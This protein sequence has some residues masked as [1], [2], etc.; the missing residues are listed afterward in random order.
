MTKSLVKRLVRLQHRYGGAMLALGPTV[1]VASVCFY[2]SIAWMTYISFTRSRLL[3]RYNWVGALQYERLLTEDR[4]HVA[5]ANLVV[6]GGCLVVGALVLGAL[7]A[8]AMDQ[9]I[10]FEGTL[11]TIF[12]Y[13]LA[14]SYVVTGLVW[15]WLLNPDFGL[16][17]V[18]RQMGFAEFHVDMLASSRLARFGI[19]AAAIWHAAGL[20]MALLLAA[21]RNVDGE[22]WRVARV[23]GI[24]TWRMYWHVILPM[25]ASAV[26]TCAVLLALQA[27]KGYDLVVAMTGG[28]PGYATDLPGKFVVD[29]AGE[30]ANLALAA[31]AAVQMMAALLVPMVIGAIVRRARRLTP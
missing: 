22:L 3:P 13:P 16:A 4:W 25:L 10:R 29:Y 9:K 28:G 20:V 1:I 24:P 7:M 14:I 27:L 31:A 17:Q 11:R 26:S 2:G 8:V 21:L 30:R 19:A 15:Q 18:V 6:F 5:M 12:L 23:E